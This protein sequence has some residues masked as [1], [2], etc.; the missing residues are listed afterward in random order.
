METK[1]FQVPGAGTRQVLLF[2]GG[3]T[4]AFLVLLYGSVFKGIPMGVGVL[5]FIGVLYACMLAAFKSRF[6]YALRTSLFQTAAVVLLGLTFMLF[7]NLILLSINGF[8]IA[9]L[10]GAQIRYMLTG[11]KE[12]LFSV[13]A[14]G[15][16][17]VVWMGYTFAGM[18][19]AF[20]EIG[21]KRKGRS[22]TGVL[23]GI[24]ITIPVLAV[25]VALL[26]SADAAFSKM[27]KDALR[28]V[29]MADIAGYLI[30]GAVLF[31][32]A[33]GLNYSLHVRKPG[34][35]RVERPAVRF[36][37]IAVLLLAFSLDAVL[38]VF[39]AF[40][41]AY[42]FAGKVPEGF[43]YATY[44]QNGFWQLVGVAVIVAVLVFLV[45]R[46][47]ASFGEG[48]R[49]VRAALVILC[50]LTEVV[51]V[52]AFW[53]MSLYEQ[54]YSFS[55]LRIF[56]QAFMVATAGVFGVLIAGLVRPGVNVKKGIFAVGML[57]YIALNFMN[58][59]AFIARQNIAIGGQAADIVYL[60]QLSVDALPY[61]ADALPEAKTADP[62]AYY[63]MNRGLFS[64]KQG[65]EKAEGWQYYNVSREEAK[66]WIQKY[67][68]IFERAETYI[69]NG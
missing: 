43:T 67:G 38:S 42:L 24:G 23:I 46:T 16:A 62:Y 10:T 61:Y 55:I 30:V 60:T 56:T 20:S 26:M 7:N 66:Q 48:S 5:I 54:A 47:T 9:V 58:V 63:H 65:V 52:S 69:T 45:N 37:R 44:A 35:V 14:V 59:D 49:P 32:L 29:D 3:I 33:A 2:S 11:Q 6:L 13:Q 28:G 39:A 1:N 8:L 22:M 41:F 25:V 51:L 21:Q 36:S 17:G 40:Q 12:S 57:C 15:D 31:F 18:K 53:R 27:I 68:D 64:V 4:A 34:T 19:G 50:A